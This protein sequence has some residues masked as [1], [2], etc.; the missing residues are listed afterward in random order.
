MQHTTRV[1]DT[2]QNVLLTKV[3]TAL[4][5]QETLSV[6]AGVCPIAENL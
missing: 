1:L 5:K 3:Q 4:G 6:N 2:I